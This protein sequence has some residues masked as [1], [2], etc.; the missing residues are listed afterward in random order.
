MKSNLEHKTKLSDKIKEFRKNRNRRKELFKNLVVIK[1]SNKVGQALSLPK[2]LNL[3]P[4]SIYNKLEE[5]KTFV[6]EEE[7]DL[8]CMSESWE[9]EELTLD[10][11][12]KID[13]YEVISNV[14]Q[15]TG[16]GGRPAIIVNTKKYH[17]ENITNTLVNIPWG[18]EIVWA[19]LTP[20]NVS[21]A[22]NIQKIVVASIY[23]KPDSRKKSVLLDH[24]AEVYNLLNA[25]YKKG[26]HWI[27]CGD[28]NDLKLDPILMLNSKLKQVVQNFTRLN[29]PR[30]LDPIITT[31]SSFYQ[32]PVCLPPL[33]SDPDLDGKPSDHMMV[34][35]SP[36]SVINNK[37]AR[38]TKKIVFRPITDSGLQKM[39]LWLEKEKWTEISQE[40]SAHRKAEL[41][42][43]LLVKKYEEFFPEKV[44]KVSSDDQPFY[45]DKLARLK[46]KKGREYR[47]RRRS[48]R[49]ISLENLYN[50]E[51][52][53]AKMDFY[54]KNIK[55]LRKAKPGKWY[56]ELKKITS[57]GHQ[58][59]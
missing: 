34:V 41:L 16:K 25:K 11:V 8:T 2:V 21:N 14:H 43:H 51:V 27:L 32:V 23:S 57:F 1:P 26:L 5:F 17:V 22:S 49:W 30:I 52:S 28:T 56:S 6:K 4:R 47:K 58:K 33:D 13:D 59:F 7:V 53:K 55:N 54:R 39:Q 12:I 24:I 20:K 50:N 46:R 35:M 3:N 38:I 48:S 31:L 15:R 29:P 42:Q 18:V 10:K 9:R 45:T 40:S 19:V 37:P 36:I 44:R